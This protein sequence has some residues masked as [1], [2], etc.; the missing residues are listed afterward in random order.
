MNALSWRGRL[1]IAALMF[2]AVTWSIFPV[3]YMISGSLKPGIEIWAY[4]P[5]LLTA[6]SFDSYLGISKLY[7]S[8]WGDLL[9]SV[10]VTLISTLLALG[11]SLS[12]AFVF[13][14]LRHGWL[15]LPALLMILVRMFPP[16]IVLIPLFPVL[17]ALGWL[18][19]MTPLV[20]SAVAFSVSVATLLL[21]TF[22]DD[23]PIEIEEAAMID[24]CS[25]LRAFV[26]ITIPLVMPAISAIALIIAIGVWN[27]YLFPLVFTSWQARTAPVTIAVAMANEDGV[28]WGV[29]L[30]MGTLH[31]IPTLTLVLLLYRQLVNVVTGGAVKG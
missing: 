31:L 11:C 5:S 22:I 19:T 12:A 30:A 1:A 17:N 9:N 15:R 27:D 7:P 16:I 2:I 8:F 24:G 3:A 29:V 6:P 20:I 18:D 14:R 4:P 28:S 10:K 21:K 25:R 13:S 26:T 23:I